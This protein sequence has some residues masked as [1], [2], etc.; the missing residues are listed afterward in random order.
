MSLKLPDPGRAMGGRYL[1]PR[2]TGKSRLLG[3]RLV[4]GDFVREIPQ[5]VFDP[6]GDTI[7][8]FLD[9]VF[10]MTKPKHERQAAA[11]RIMY[12]DVGGGTG[13][14]CPLPVYHRSEFDQLDQ[15]A[16][17][18]IDV[19][20]RIDPALGAAPI[21]GLNAV[22]TTGLYTGMVLSA[23]GWRMSEAE[24]LLSDPG[25]YRERILHAVS[26]DYKLREAAV[27]LQNLKPPTTREWHNQVD[28]FLNKARQITLNDAARA[29]YC[30][31]KPGFSWQDVVDRG[32]TVLLDFR[33]FADQD[34][35]RVFGLVWWFRSL[36]GFIKKRGAGRHTPI[37]LVIDELWHFLS[38]NA[39]Q[40]DLIAGDFEELVVTRSR[41]H[42]VWLSLSHQ[43]LNQ[44]S[45]RM[46]NVLMSLGT[47]IFAGTS[48]L[49]EGAE[50]WAKRFDDFELLKARAHRN[51][52][53]S[54]FRGPDYI[55]EE[56]PVLM[57]IQEQIRKTAQEKYMHL[58]PLTFW[59]AVASREGELG[60]SPVR[61]TVST[62]DGFVDQEKVTIARKRLAERSGR[63]ITE[64]LAEIAERIPDGE[65][66]T[67][68][69]KARGPIHSRPVR[70]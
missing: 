58:P 11:E 10:D 23:L 7:D 3:R 4:Y 9:V 28:S 68:G 29:T 48:D 38:G 63:L 59:G 13:Y 62:E 70:S 33:S 54:A 60:R 47:Q 14:V 52:W 50:V 61:F 26:D 65:S 18:P 6:V 15:V 56:Q 45:R 42:Q 1:G 16:A 20:R 31:V 36:F 32:Q 24:A 22:L 27:W 67:P 49:E 2:G 40:Q 43:E 34:D 57:T 44:L 64:V 55:R 41:S 37:G 12:V 21:M 46:G 51:V 5:V 39:D 8:N 66:E 30:A 17:R 35:L 53:G 69:A 19:W 25:R